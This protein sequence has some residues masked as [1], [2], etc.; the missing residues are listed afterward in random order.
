MWS[1]PAAA[2]EC[3]HLKERQT[4][5]L[6]HRADVL[7]GSVGSCPRPGQC[8]WVQAGLPGLDSRATG[9]EGRE[10]EQGES[11]ASFSRRLLDWPPCGRI[12]R[13]A[14]LCERDECLLREREE[15]SRH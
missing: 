1:S 3:V 11:L 15:S 4:N 5:R 2:P 7:M 10:R 14:T 9:L 6:R 8:Q 13:V 12:P